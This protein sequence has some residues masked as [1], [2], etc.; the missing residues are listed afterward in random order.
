MRRRT[1]GCLVI[2]LLPGSHTLQ[3]IHLASYAEAAAA[4][5]GTVGSPIPR[6]SL[7][8]APPAQATARPRG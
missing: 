1:A 5:L 8:S 7:H 2:F 3:F 6:P 4:G